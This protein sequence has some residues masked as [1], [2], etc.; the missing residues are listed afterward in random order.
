MMSVLLCL[1]PLGAASIMAIYRLLRGPT[2]LDR[3]IGF[4]LLTVCVIGMVALI[5]IWRNTHLY[6]E[7][8]IIFSVLGFIGTVAFVT[9][10]H[11][12]SDTQTFGREE[13]Q[14]ISDHKENFRP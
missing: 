9:Y 10:L 3:I 6:I 13:E 8:M 11:S 7:M 4:D 12:Y 14:N 2:V 5:S 1:V